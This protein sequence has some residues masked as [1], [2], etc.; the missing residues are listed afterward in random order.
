MSSTN[1]ARATSS[2]L[3]SIASN[4]FLARGGGSNHRRI[5]S[6]TDEPPDNVQRYTDQLNTLV[7]DLQKNI[8]PIDENLASLFVAAC[9]STVLAKAARDAAVKAR[10]EA[11]DD[12]Q[13]ADANAVTA[14]VSSGSEAKYSTTLKWLDTGPSRWKRRSKAKLAPPNRSMTITAL[15]CTSTWGQRENLARGTGWEQS[16]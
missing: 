2:N 7:Q 14:A 6:P 12:Q 13:K 11:T 3:L 15:D 9:E 4:L 10:D 16:S 1:E 5:D 8:P